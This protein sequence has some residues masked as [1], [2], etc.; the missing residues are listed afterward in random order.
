[1]AIIDDR[2]NYSAITFSFLAAT[3]CIHQEKNYV[4]EF[5]LPL[6][7]TF[8]KLKVPISSGKDADGKLF[9]FTKVV[10]GGEKHVIYI[11]QNSFC[12]NFVS[13]IFNETYFLNSLMMDLMDKLVFDKSLILTKKKYPKLNSKY[14][15][16]RIYLYSHIEWYAAIKI[17]RS[18]LKYSSNPKYK[19]CHIY[20]LNKVV[21]ETDL[22]ELNDD[23]KNIHYKY[24][25]DRTMISLRNK[26]LKTNIYNN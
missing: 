6:K 10:V 13:T 24:L 1:M 18:W 25:F 15:N 9:I 5:Y 4:N 7:Y 16:K 20:N 8:D 11:F 19:Y 23:F 12:F 26:F 21:Y 3:N 2:T 22:N 14:E 17:Q